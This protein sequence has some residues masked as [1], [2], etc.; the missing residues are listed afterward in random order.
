VT[1]PPTI[2][3]LAA[4]VGA[5]LGSGPSPSPLPPSS[6][7]RVCSDGS[8][9]FRTVTGEPWRYACVSAFKLAELYRRGESIDPFLN[10]YRALGYTV[11][12][13]WDYVMWTIE[14]NGLEGWDSPGPDVWLDF[15]QYVR[16]RGWYVELTVWTGDEPDRV[17]PGVALMQDLC[18]AS[19]DNLL[20]EGPNENGINGKQIS[21]PAQHEVE[22]LCAQMAIP[23]CGW[24]WTVDD[25]G[26]TVQGDHFGTYLT[27]HTPRDGEWPRKCH[28]LLEYYDGGGPHAKDDPPHRMPCLA[29]EPI[30]PDQAGYVEKDF[31]DYAAGCSLLGGGVTFH[32]ETGK[33]AAVPTADEHRCA[34]ATADGFLVF[35]A[36][37]P[38]GRYRRIDE[39]DPNTSARTY[40]MG[41]K[42]MVRIRASWPDCPEPGWTPLDDIGVCWGK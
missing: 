19:P 26:N 16:A 15:I 38:L 28:D 40:V 35:P 17:E 12:R 14:A 41:E 5:T 27:A 9:I 30:R 22:T 10:T 18:A 6:L 42:W 4:A 36:D 37:A 29:D 21:M 25:D 20:V 11:L 3:P 32:S 31:Y 33:V 8:R 24:G 23:F 39:H 13:V 7:A 34:L 2:I 1:L